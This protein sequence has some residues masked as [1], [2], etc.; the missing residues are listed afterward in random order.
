MSV[1]S[2]RVMAARNSGLAGCQR[3]PLD[4]HRDGVHGRDIAVA[5][6]AA[7]RHPLQA[8]RLHLDHGEQVEAGVDEQ[9]VEMDAPAPVGVGVGR[10]QRE[11]ALQ[12]L[13]RLL[14]CTLRR[15]LHG[16]ALRIVGGAL[17]LTDRRR[18]GVVI[19]Q[20]GHGAVGVAEA[21][22][23][24]ERE[25][26]VQ[27]DTAQAGQVLL[28]RLAHQRVGEAQPA[29]RLGLQQQARSDRGVEAVEGERIGL[30]GDRRDDAG[31]ELRPRDGRD[32]QEV[33]G[34][35]REPCDAPPDD[36]AHPVGDGVV[37]RPGLGEMVYQ[38]AHEERVALGLLT[39]LPGERGVLG[40]HER[41]DVLAIEAA[42]G[43]AL[44]VLLA[45]QV[46]ERGAERMLAVEL[47][48]AVGGE[49]QDA[50]HPLAAGQVEERLK[51]RLRGPVQVVEGEDER[52]A[53]GLVG[54]PVHEPFEHRPRLDLA[55]RQVVDQLGN[56][57]SEH[58]AAQAEH[59]LAG[60]VI[61]AAQVVAQRFGKRLV[62]DLQMLVDAAEQHERALPVRADCQLTGETGLAGAW[63]TAEQHDLPRALGCPAPRRLQA[64]H[65]L[66]P[67]D[68]RP[69]RLGGDT[70]RQRDRGERVV[71]GQRRPADLDGGAPAPQA[72][73]APPARAR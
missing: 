35:R 61:D 9:R 17:A 4:R 49:D 67:A 14:R 7:E 56:Q 30:V 1:C 63:L 6:L 36:V 39:D 10:E 69:R 47:G 66:R 73:S 41:D 20:L 19:G 15:G 26:A 65:L 21:L 28:Q 32:A 46:G 68:E 11:R 54:Q 8:D 37:D 2:A 42:D 18:R 57:P 27:V 38:L 5:Q 13:D 22:F 16:G 50:R 33:A 70:R 59:L 62:G 53:G 52:A 12:Q 29:G 24:R 72:P 25:V 45:P 58:A 51:R 43:H 71:L 64:R 40:A 34:L 55:G 44:D 31:L 23:E 48:V 60:R 3:I